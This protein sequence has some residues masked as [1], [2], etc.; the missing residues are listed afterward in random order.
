MQIHIVTEKK[1]QR[2]ILRPWSEALARE[3]PNVSIGTNI[4]PSAEVNIFIN[5]A[6]YK[7]VQGITAAVFTHRE[8][9][10]HLATLFDNV[11]QQVDWCFAQCLITAALLP[12]GKT[13]ILPLYPDPMFYKDPPLV[14]GVVGR[15]YK[16]GRKRMEWIEDLEQIQGVEVRVASKVPLKDMPSFYDNIDYLV[17][18]ADNE[19][20]P[21]P[22]LEALVRGK[23]VIASNVG[24][25]WEYP[26]VRYTTK[27][28]LLNL[29]R[30]LIL[31]RNGWRQSALIVQ[32]VFRRLLGEPKPK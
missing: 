1:S 22:V 8:H 21:Q 10:G 6:L 13:T 3:L 14:L 24:Y 16:S 26:V 11:A 17:I 29:V 4:D 32:E 30:K 7:P 31:P 25:C 5:Y 18:L 27:D 2:W 19:G 9:Q 28:D 15:P 12:V 23:P 20:G